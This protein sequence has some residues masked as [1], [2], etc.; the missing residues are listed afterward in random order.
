MGAML[1]VASG[2]VALGVAH[3]VSALDSRASSPIVA[4]GSTA[5]DIAP[6]WLKSLA[7]RTFGAQ[8]KLVLLVGIG[9]V[10]TVLAVVLG[11]AS[12]R[13]P[14]IG[15]AGLTLLAAAGALAA[16]SRPD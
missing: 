5:I 13:R 7:I 11:V 1:G 2:A 14:R 8:D 9:A 15:L 16:L 12:L 10:V 4:V 3:L 6:E